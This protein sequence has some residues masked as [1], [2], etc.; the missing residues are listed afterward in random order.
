[1]KQVRTY[2]LESVR[3]HTHTRALFACIQVYNVMVLIDHRAFFVCLCCVSCAPWQPPGLL[4]SPLQKAG[5]IVSSVLPLRNQLANQYM[6]RDLMLSASSSIM[7]IQ[8]NTQAVSDG[9]NL[10]T[11]VCTN[12]ARGCP[13]HF[14][15]GK[16]GYL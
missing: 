13:I 4:L 5:H 11:K 3:K 7:R 16:K 12:I 10:V 8:I 1:M 9:V 6:E 2:L 14:W 15:F